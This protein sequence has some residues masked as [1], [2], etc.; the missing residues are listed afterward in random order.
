M[1]GEEVEQFAAGV[2]AH[3]RL[4]PVEQ[5]PLVDVRPLASLVEHVPIRRGLGREPLPVNLVLVFALPALPALRGVHLARGGPLHRLIPPVELGEDLQE[6]LFV[7][8]RVVRV[9]A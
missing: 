4:G 2:G 1:F 3:P 7:G 9:G 5:G 8:L 6:S